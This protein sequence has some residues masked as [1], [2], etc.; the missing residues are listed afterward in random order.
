MTEEARWWTGFHPPQTAE[1]WTS[2]IMSCFPGLVTAAPLSVSDAVLER[3]TPI[4]RAIQRA[5][6]T[7]RTAEEWAREIIRKAAVPSYSKDAE[8]QPWLRESIGDLVRRIPP[9]SCR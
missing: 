6:G 3:I 9:S 2:E 8:N 7:Q 4:V 5:A 1:E